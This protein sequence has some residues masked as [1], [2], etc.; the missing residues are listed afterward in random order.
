MRIGFFTDSYLPTSHGVTSSIE[1]F[2]K[3]LEKVGHEVFVYATYVPG[4]KDVSPVFRFEALRIIKKPDMRLALPM[5]HGGSMKSAVDFKLDI[6][7]AQT[8]FGVGLLGK[9][10][11]KRQGI[12]IIYTHHTDYPEYAKLYLKEQFISPYLAT[13]LI[14]SFGNFSDAIIAPSE[15][16]RSNLKQYGLEKPIYMIPNGI[17]IEEF[18][19]NKDSKRKCDRIREVLKINK[20][21]RV[22]LYLGRLCKEKN[23]DFLIRAFRK[24]ADVNKNIKFI[25]AGDGPEYKKLQSLAKRLGIGSKVIFCGF[26]PNIDK[27]A[28]YQLS[29]V[30]LFASKTDTQGIVILEAIAS[31]L[32]IVALR[33]E[34][35]QGMI[36]D[37][38]NG[39]MI[40]SNSYDNFAMKVAN[41]LNDKKLQAKLSKNLQKIA[42]NYSEDKETYKLLDLYDSLLSR[43]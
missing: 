29:D 18:Q 12:P 28:Y 27:A 43:K 4:Y 41:I 13:R 26:V 9:L 6:V 35:F 19:R 10:I 20:N 8:P 30:F 23:I 21:D 40:D 32:P 25:I 17:N 34:A 5:L 37:G 24:I 11:A 7:H 14:K 16:V 36:Q 2:R 1:S 3:S 39:F 22:L 31:G 33:D 38:V 42:E 15:K